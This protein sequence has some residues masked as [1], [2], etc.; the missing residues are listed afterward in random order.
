MK[1]SLQ[2][3]ATCLDLP[4]HT[5]ERWI[6]QGRIPIHRTGNLCVFKPQSLAKWAR[7]HNVRFR[8]P[9][10][11][12]VCTAEGCLESLS[13]AM[14]RGGVAQDISGQTPEQLL[15]GMVQTIPDLPENMKP[16]LLE[17]LLERERLSSTGVGNGIALPHPR[18]PLDTFPDLPRILTA[19]PASP[20][21][22]RALDDK[23][24]HTFF[25]LLAPSVPEHLS[26]LSRL[27]YCLR[28]PSFRDFLSER[29][30][31]A[32]LFDRVEEMEQTL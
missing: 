9:D 3:T 20:V 26:L 12:P 19:Y 23:P 22:Y 14:R 18:S 30:S 8:L 24:V 29:P 2:E 17:R 1:L 21:D 6:R 4:V 11:G 10:E 27:S 13:T 7:Q 31:A 32:R 28:E 15:G 16:E 5:V 25:L